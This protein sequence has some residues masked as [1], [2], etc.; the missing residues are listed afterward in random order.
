MFRRCLL[1][2]A[3]FAP[4]QCSG[5]HPAGT[6]QRRAGGAGHVRT[7]SGAQRRHG[8][9]QNNWDSPGCIQ[10]CKCERLPPKADLAFSRR[11]PLSGFVEGKRGSSLPVYSS[12]VLQALSYDQKE[13]ASS[14]SKPSRDIIEPHPEVGV[15][16]RNWEGKMIVYNQ[17]QKEFAAVE[18]EILKVFEATPSCA[19]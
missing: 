2:D 13:T 10:Q 7:C 8:R 1:L 15:C 5:C 17:A 19:N 9:S 12:A 18:E 3:G 14:P 16:V 6:A 4:H 11:P